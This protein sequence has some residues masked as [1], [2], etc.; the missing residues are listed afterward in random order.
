MCG[1]LYF[2]TRTP[3]LMVP[4]PVNF[5]RSFASCAHWHAS[6]ILA[7]AGLHGENTEVTVDPSLLAPAVSGH[8]I[9]LEVPDPSPIHVSAD[10]SAPP[11]ATNAGMSRLLHMNLEQLADGDPRDL[12]GM[13][14]V[15]AQL[16]GMG[17]DSRSRTCRTFFVDRAPVCF[18]RA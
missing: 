1:L 17:L 4:T 7:V 10:L 9:G 2:N 13:S 14:S 18:A 8:T 6:S 3:S 15:L 5:I 16:E 12:A 11:V